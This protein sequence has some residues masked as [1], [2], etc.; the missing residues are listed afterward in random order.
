MVK[1]DWTLF[2]LSFLSVSDPSNGIRPPFEAWTI[3]RLPL[4]LGS[5]QAQLD[6]FGE[7]HI[8]TIS[9]VFGVRWEKWGKWL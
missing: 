9:I 5:A 2:L 6:L 8:F 7:K 4:C 1:I 3:W